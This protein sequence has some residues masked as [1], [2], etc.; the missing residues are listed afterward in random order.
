MSI[1]FPIVSPL[2]TQLSIWQ[3]CTDKCV[4]AVM[5]IWQFET[6]SQ[7]EQRDGGKQQRPSSFAAVVKWQV[8]LREA[9]ITRV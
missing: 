2:W 8:P 7:A 9:S 5:E 6:I 1:F 3:H 4:D